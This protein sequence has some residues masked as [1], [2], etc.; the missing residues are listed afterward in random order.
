MWSR[1]LVELLHRLTQMNMTEGMLGQLLRNPISWFEKRHVGDLFAR[2]KAQ[3]EISALP[4][5]PSSRQAST[6]RSDALALG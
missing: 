6:S 2:V 4:P 5:A 1:Y 3:D